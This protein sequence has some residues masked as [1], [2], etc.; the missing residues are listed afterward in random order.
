MQ[1]LIHARGAGEAHWGDSPGGDVGEAHCRTDFADLLRGGAG[2]VGGRDNGAGADSADVMNRN[3]IL[4]ENAQHADV[5]DSTGKAAAQRQ[6]D[7]TGRERGTSLGRS[8]PA[9]NCS[10]PFTHYRIVRLAAF[11]GA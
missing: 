1:E 11:H 4:L 10:E 5:S 2:R 6:S 3:V 9:A 7:G 8:A